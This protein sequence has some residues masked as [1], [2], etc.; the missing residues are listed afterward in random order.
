M[1]VQILHT[2]PT[3]KWASNKSN[4]S[5]TSYCAS[6]SFLRSRLDE[7]E[8]LPPRF[9]SEARGLAQASP[10]L[11]APRLHALETRDLLHQ[12]N[13]KGKVVKIKTRRYK[14]LVWGSIFAP[15]DFWRRSWGLLVGCRSLALRGVASKKLR[16]PLA[17]HLR[18]T[19]EQLSRSS[20]EIHFLTA[21]H[22]NQKPECIAWV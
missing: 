3:Q 20:K 22:R 6:C 19:T 15:E 21:S 7:I 8:T 12:H 11:E 5:V 10:S 16:L 17:C 1:G 13:R 14:R 4:S 2:F 18:L 9:A